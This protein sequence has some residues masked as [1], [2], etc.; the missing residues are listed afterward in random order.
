MY[1]I[2]TQYIQYIQYIQDVQYIQYILTTL[3]YFKRLPTSCNGGRIIV[4]VRFVFGG[5]PIYFK[6]LPTSWSHLLHPSDLY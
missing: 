1:T 5:I 4:F 2:C 3:I 6:R